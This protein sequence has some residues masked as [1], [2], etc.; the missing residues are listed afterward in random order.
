MTT[1]VKPY[2]V[3]ER[4]REI[5]DRWFPRH[6]AKLTRYTAPTSD[7]GVQVIEHLRWAEPGTGVN[8]IDYVSRGPYLYVTGDL[9]D[10]T[11]CRAEGL[12]WWAGLS[13]D[14]FAE[15]CDA[16]EYGRGYKSWDP[17]E[18]RFRAEEHFRRDIEEAL[19]EDYAAKYR[20]RYQYF[21]ENGGPSA[22]YHEQEWAQW[23]SEHGVEA[24]GDDYWEFG[25]FGRVIH[26][27]CHGHL[28]GLK[29]AMAQ[30][31]EKGSDTSKKQEANDD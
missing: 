25:M 21:K 6:V 23:L 22:L 10:A 29:R 28:Q 4:Q 17:D 7:G 12:S 3:W 15:K 19:D 2:N 27:R 13:I 16:S 11:Y 9:G 1:A 26:V 30:L 8:L 20:Q 5:I 24:L 18:A 14:Y 31:R